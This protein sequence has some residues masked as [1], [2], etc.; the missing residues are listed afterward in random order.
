MTPHVSIIV[1]A[2]NAA[3][4][5]EACLAAL[6]PSAAAGAEILVVDDASTDATA[7]IARRIGVRV[8]ANGS[9]HRGP[10]AARNF[11]VRNSSGEILVFVDADV[12]VHPG[13]VERAV[14]T[15]DAEP[16]VGAVTGAYDENPAAPGDISQWRNLLH[17]YTHRVA[18][19][20][21]HTF[22]TGFGV[23]RR[24]VFESAGGLNEQIR[25]LEDMDLGHRLHRVGVKL[26]LDASL[27][28]QHRKRWT[29]RSMIHTDVVG[30]AIPYTRILLR[31]GNDH[32]LNTRGSQEA[33]V[34][35]AWLATGTLLAA[36]LFW[37]LLWV[38]L[39]CLAAVAAVN[40]DFYRFLAGCRGTAFAIRMFP[41]H[42]LF[43]FYSGLGYLFERTRQATP[44]LVMGWA[45]PCAVFLALMLALQWD[46]GAFGSESFDSDEPAHIVTGLM[47]RDYLAT[48]LPGPP[49]AFAQQYYAHYPK[50]AMGHWPPVFYAEQALWTMLF[51]RSRDSLLVLMALLAALLAT[52]CYRLLRRS[53][54]PLAGWCGA[55]VLLTVPGMLVYGTR[56]YT[57]IPQA[58]LI[59]LAALALG[60][61]LDSG[62][63]QDA[64][65]FGGLASASLLTKGTGL[66]LAPLPLLGVAFTRRWDLLRRASF[67][68]PA[69][70]VLAVAGPW[71]ALAPGA[72]HERAA[73]L[74]GP[75][76]A[77]S[78]IKAPPI[79]WHWEFGWGVATL[80]L[81][82]LAW[83][84]VRCWRQKLSGQWAAL[85]SLV[86][87]ASVFPF[88]FGVWEH[89]HQIEAVGAFLLMAAAGVA[90]L[91]Q[92]APLARL[93]AAA[94]G[95]LVVA[96]AGGLMAWNV[97]GLSK[98]VPT[99]YRELAARIVHETGE[100]R[101][102]LI[103][104][105]SAGEGALIS[106]IAQDEDHPRHY[107]LRATKLL[108]DV[109]WLGGNAKTRFPSAAE[110][111]TFLRSIPLDVIVV[112]TMSPAPYDYAPVLEEVLTSHP[113][114]WSPWSATSDGDRFHVFRRQGAT[115][116]S[117]EERNRR[118]A[119]LT[120][121]PNL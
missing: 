113:E 84:A 9:P 57:E 88:F 53:Y 29:L 112:D 12:V 97:A 32:D 71:Y 109:G 10:S 61:Y 48:G 50:V 40:L 69:V 95:G 92:A 87:S 30:R 22:W 81:V 21:T 119:E 67:W 31:E 102:V 8:L 72:L 70:I 90:A 111:D 34:S 80:A 17:C 4:D 58:L 75:T 99:G 14:A 66:A 106:E 73:Y 39:A 43:F 18:H 91:L 16:E 37:P 38:T 104:A 49:M 36:P 60:R 79:I 44:A 59:L 103:S 114:E 6:A 101:S 11:G 85:G 117:A 115:E 2:H 62:R 51:P 33:S 20:D 5:I 19:R 86:I 15:L 35:L 100:S 96:L 108:A 55:L 93:T 45:A 7:E 13:V 26:R 83:L 46:A 68:L 107:V 76:V 42:V 64:A 121:L 65:L 3:A 89:R 110:L 82:G 63:W 1:P 77:T 118:L 23:I 120:G 116:I 94:R 56:I 47:V 24:S 27:E 74:G 28:V 98:Q 54:G 52:L 78:R 25:Y 41:C 105:S